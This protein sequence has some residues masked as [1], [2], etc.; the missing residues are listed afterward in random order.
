MRWTN[1]VVSVA[2]LC[3]SCLASSTPS[4]LTSISRRNG[5]TKQESVRY[6]YRGAKRSP[7]EIRAR[8]GFRPLGPNWSDN[9]QAFSIDRHFI[10]GIGG[11]DLDQDSFE[12][13][14]TAYVSFSREQAFAS[15]Y[16]SWLYEVH[17][18][19]N[20]LDPSDV[21]VYP[22]AE[23][24]ALGGVRWSQV[25]RFKWLH[26]QNSEWMPNPEYAK[27]VWEN[28]PVSGTQTDV[29]KQLLDQDEG[30]WEKTEARETA[31]EYMGRSDMKASLGEFP[32]RF[33][34]YPVRED[35]PG[36]RE[37]P[38]RQRVVFTEE[39]I[40]QREEF[41]KWLNMCK[42]DDSSCLFAKGGKDKLA[43][44]EHDDFV[45]L[46]EELA[47][48][49]FEHLAIKFGVAKLVEHH[50]KLSLSDLH[51]LSKGYKPIATSTIRRV[52]VWGARALTVPL[53]GLY[54]KDVV[55]VFSK[56]TTALDRAAV[57]TSIVPF[58]GCGVQAAANVQNQQTDLA[59]TALCLVGDALLL[60]PAWP[61]GLVVHFSRFFLDAVRDYFH[62][63]NLFHQDTVK[64]QETEGWL[65]YCEEVNK[66]IQSSVF[67]ANIRTQ[68]MAELAVV[69]SRASQARAE[70]MLGAEKLVRANSTTEEAREKIREDVRDKM[71][72]IEQLICFRA[73]STKEGLRTTFR[74]ALKR[75]MLNQH[76][77]YM[78][79][80]YR[81]LRHEAVNRT[82]TSELGFVKSLDAHVLAMKSLDEPSTVVPTGT[83]DS[84]GRAI[85]GHIDRLQ[86]PSPCQVVY[87]IVPPVDGSEE[88]LV[89]SRR[90]A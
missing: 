62:I 48:K 9:P 74:Q 90:R 68:Y 36:P 61:L 60:T 66:Y 27:D 77:Q 63:T 4:S 73:A 14:E 49:D 30:N 32:H 59:D 58:V 10:A 13:F 87:K 64:K 24:F 47:S 29:P 44:S 37:V 3:L 23:V 67:E 39:E 12:E 89:T 80:F 50:E 82:S 76:E 34:A 75:W 8:G 53:L 2:S 15:R 57:V 69:V 38:P 52:K 42:R 78:V 16:G 72:L 46:S 85:D 19:R 18:T 65:A 88:E 79:N 7:Q 11:S 28:S 1:V 33:E 43:L 40:Q 54:A 56:D 35:I 71:G 41:F 5:G 6:L 26:D 81:A 25:V 83:L 20:V 70:L 84:L 21:Y 45:R 55:D 22:D 31:I 17:A 51:G 86:T